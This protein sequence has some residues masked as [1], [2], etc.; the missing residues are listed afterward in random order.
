MTNPKRGEIELKLG[1]KTFKAKVTLD[2]IIK[3]ETALNCGIVKVL[4]KLTDANLTTMEMVSILTP[5]IRGGGNDL[6]E[7]DIREIVW[8][9]GIA[10]TMNATGEILAKALMGEDEGGNEKKAAVA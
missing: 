4:Q 7:K 2:A 6:S 3:I 5:I 8:E 10:G 1:P 9:A